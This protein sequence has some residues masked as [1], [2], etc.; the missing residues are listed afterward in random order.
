MA[1]NFDKL[2]TPQSICIIYVL[3]SSILILIFRSFFI[4]SEAPLV[5]Y[6]RS[7]RSIQGMSY[8]LNLFPALVL[9]GLVIPFSFFSGFID[10]KQQSFTEAFSRRFFASVM[11]AIFAV[12]VYAIIFFFTLPML[13]NQEENLRFNSELYHL[14]KNNAIESIEAGEWDAAAQYINI[15]NLIW[16]NSPELTDLKDRV[17][18]RLEARVFEQSDERALAR[19]ALAR[20]RRDTGMQAGIA[21]SESQYA[22]DATDAIMLSRAAFNERRFFDAHWLA[23][24]GKRLAPDGSAQENAAARLASEA[25]NMITLQAPTQREEQLFR[26]HNMKLSG[27]QAINSERWIE[28]FYIFQELLSLTPDDPDVI[29]FLALSERHAVRSAFF[30]DE[31]NMSFGEIINSALYSLPSDNGRMVMRFSALTISSD[32]AY[33]MG[34]EYMKFDEYNNLLASVT[35][36]YAK[37]LPFTIDDKPQILVLTHA[38]DRNNEENASKSEWL[39]GSERYSGIHQTFFVLDMSFEDFIVASHIRRGLSNLQIFELFNAASKLKTIGYIPQVFHAE[40][41]NRLG[42]V[43]FFLPIAI[44]AIILGWRYRAIKKPRYLLI[45]ML[46]VLPIVFNGL[47]YLYNAVSNTLGIWLILSIGFMPALILFIVI[48]TLLLFISLLVLSAQQ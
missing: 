21:P 3:L 43:L 17:N 15:C 20:D 41:L 31:M 26:L 40:I 37:L 7:W 45:P 48:F 2:R 46:L 24:L 32:F 27:Y 18:H 12:I 35:S 34:L 25:W 33:G 47:I 1:I 5:I 16:L 29:N 36:R 14:S 8:V 28:A 22:V 38:L 19:T 4:G 9:S 42:S 10:D 11:T 23:N 6:A 13:K 30:I 39:F 44:F